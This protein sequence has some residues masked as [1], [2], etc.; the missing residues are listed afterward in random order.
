MQSGDIPEA[1]FK[2]TEPRPKLADLSLI[3]PAG[4]I[5]LGKPGGIPP[6]GEPAFTIDGSTCPLTMANPGPGWGIR[7]ESSDMCRMGVEFGCSVSGAF[8]LDWTRGLVDSGGSSLSGAE[9]SSLRGVD[10][11]DALSSSSALEA[12]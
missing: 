4:D 2:D 5:C 8:V 12:P 6:R 3:G 1:S 11:R 10:A 7:F 9:E